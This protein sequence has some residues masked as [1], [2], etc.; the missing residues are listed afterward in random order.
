MRFREIVFN[1]KLVWTTLCYDKTQRKRRKL[2]HYLPKSAKI[3]R[4]RFWTRAKI[5]SI[6]FFSPRF[7]PCKTLISNLCSSLVF[8]CYWCIAFWR[9]FSNVLITCV[10][11][12]KDRPSR[13]FDETLSIGVSEFIILVIVQIGFQDFDLQ[14]FAVTPIIIFT[15]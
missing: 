2:T 15:T 4:G 9:C 8:L 7:F 5:S 10:L 14:G 12:L 3:R 13:Q 1:R 6:S 11:T